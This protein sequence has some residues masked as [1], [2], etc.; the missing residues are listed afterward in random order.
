VAAVEVDAGGEEVGVAGQTEGGEAAAV[1]AAPQPDAPR[2]DLR[3]LPE[4]APGGQDVAVLGS[5]ARPLVGRLA[6]GAAVADAAAEVDREH[7]RTAARPDI[8]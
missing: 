5:A 2:I 1:G 6:E 7:D 8:G 3:T 4:V